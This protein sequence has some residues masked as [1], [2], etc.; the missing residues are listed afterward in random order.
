M[1]KKNFYIA[2]GV[3][4]AAS[5]LVVFFLPFSQVI[6]EWAAIPVIGSLCGAL[7]QISRDRIAHERSLLVL[8]SQNSFSMGATSHMAGVAFDKYS[9]FCE[10][11]VAEMFEA[12]MTLTREGPR[13]SALRHGDN[14]I[15]IRRRWAVWLTPSLEND[16][17]PFE[18]ALRTI[19]VDAH[20]LEQAPGS[21]AHINEMY[22]IFARVIGLERWEGE[23]L[24]DELT[25][26][27][28]VSRLR[29]VLG[30]E[31]LNRLRSELVARALRK[32]G[33]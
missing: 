20:I 6:R 5:T 4:F 9:A 26:A 23:P 2:I 27:A 13:Q 28:V 15:K 1:N 10:E 14:L 12:L 25:V 31:E 29:R 33:D 11:Y 18:K 16:L 22:S 7:L 17:W 3:V 30:A 32:A 19:G 21:S 24:T 8:E